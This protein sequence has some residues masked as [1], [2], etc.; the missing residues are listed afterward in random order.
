[1][2]LFISLWFSCF[3]VILSDSV[4]P[5]VFIVQLY[6]L[7]MD[8]AC[9]TLNNELVIFIVYSLFPF[10]FICLLSYFKFVISFPCSYAEGTFQKSIH[11]GWGNK[12]TNYLALKFFKSLVHLSMFRQETYVYLHT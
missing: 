9:T 8:C 11:L 2:F 12:G 6:N 5:V 7:C 10:C 3:V 4:F 1:M